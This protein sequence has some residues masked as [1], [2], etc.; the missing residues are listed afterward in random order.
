VITRADWVLYDQ[1]AALRREGA[2][3]SEIQ[4][5]LRCA[6]YAVRKALKWAGMIRGRVR[7]KIPVCGPRCE[8]CDILLSEQLVPRI[9]YWE[10]SVDNQRPETVCD[11]CVAEATP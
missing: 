1:I 5:E 9:D 6:H 8:R 7:R 2:T 4:E 3:Y 11:Q 10:V